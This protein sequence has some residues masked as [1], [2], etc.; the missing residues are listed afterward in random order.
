MGIG[1]GLLFADDPD[2]TVV[3]EGGSA[4]DAARIAKVDQPD[5]IFL[6]VNMPGGGVRA[7]ELVRAID[8]RVRIIMF[9][10][11]QDVAIVRACLEAGASGYVVKGLNGHELLEVARK[12]LANG[13]VHIDARILDDGALDALRYNQTLA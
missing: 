5:L 2:F 3:A 9:S 11:R 4:D 6:D 10:I 12:V 8:T 1:V 7:V 13:G